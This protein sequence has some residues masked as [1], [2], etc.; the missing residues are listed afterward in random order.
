M[1]ASILTQSQAFYLG[2]LVMEFSNHK[3]T[4]SSGIFWI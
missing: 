3:G 4:A 2:A 1:W